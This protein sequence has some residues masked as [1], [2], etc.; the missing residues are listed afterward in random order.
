MDTLTAIRTGEPLPVP[1]QLLFGG[2]TVD[3]ELVEV[4]TPQPRWDSPD[5]DEKLDA[6]CSSL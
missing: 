2:C 1:I 4:F 6:R 3:P 5:L